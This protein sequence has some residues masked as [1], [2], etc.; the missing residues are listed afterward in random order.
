M[1][2]L[3]ELKEML[4]SMMVAWNR[5]QKT[6][7]VMLIDVKG[8]AYRLPG[9][10]MMMA[11]DGQMC[12]TISG[13][14]L[15]SDLYGWAEKV[16]TSETSI[17][18]TYDLSEN[19]I[20]S[21][22]VGCKGDLEFLITP[23]KQEDVFWRK[24]N[25]MTQNNCAFILLLEV[26]SG[27]RLVIKEDGTVYGDADRIPVEVIEQ[28]FKCLNIKTR[29]TIYSYNDKRYVVDVVKPSEHLIVVGAGRDAVPVVEL[30]RKAGFAVSVLDART[31]FNNEKYFPH[32]SS[33][34][35]QIEEVKG[36]DLAN[37]W[38][39]IMN[40][41]LE[42]DQASLK[43]AIESEPK[44]IGVL[45]PMSRTQEMLDN[46]QYSFQSGPIYAPIGLDI[47]AETMDEVA[48]SIVSQLMSI[49][50]G[51]KA[52]PLHGKVKIHG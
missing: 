22:G 32:T 13:G 39:I 14:C 49:R 27:A 7:L 24:V 35:L 43:L 12:G 6:A 19:D 11:S 44:F 50:T 16:I 41:H 46:I 18:H 45:G 33:I 37:S 40:H 26:P 48:I 23:I 15:E 2:R 5:N 8:S 36:E 28:G 9:T 25:E 31:D 42:K 38:W 17:V 4:D 1:S 10:K 51:K 47:G 52:K 30:A 34:V 29:A 20:W 21:L 3:Q